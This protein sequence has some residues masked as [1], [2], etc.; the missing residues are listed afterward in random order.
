[1]M[2]TEKMFSNPI[3]SIKLRT[4]IVFAI[5]IVRT[6]IF[7]KK[8]KFANETSFKFLCKIFKIWKRWET[9]AAF[10]KIYR[11]EFFHVNIS[12]VTR[13]VM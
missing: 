4:Q 9:T 1:M 2:K 8:V 7:L 11:V 13:S 10:W 12:N 6:I 5:M 3:L